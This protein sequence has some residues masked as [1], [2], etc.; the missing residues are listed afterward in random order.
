MISGSETTLILPLISFE[1]FKGFE[2]GVFGEHFDFGFS[3]GF[4]T[5]DF[6][7]KFGFGFGIGEEST[8]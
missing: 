7:E 6:G 5:G 3:N 8:F 2:N 4:E 1:L